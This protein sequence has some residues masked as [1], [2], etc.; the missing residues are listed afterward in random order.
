MVEPKPKHRDLSSPPLPEDHVQPTD[1]QLTLE[2]STQRDIQY[3]NQLSALISLYLV[4]QA[5]AFIRAG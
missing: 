5:C 2:A 4:D 3:L 1:I